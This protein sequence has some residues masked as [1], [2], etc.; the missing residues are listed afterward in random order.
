MMIQ[1]VVWVGAVA[2]LM[3]YLKRRRGRK[4]TS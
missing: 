1:G 3:F 2:T 4:T